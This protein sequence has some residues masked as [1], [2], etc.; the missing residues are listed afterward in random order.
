MTTL[1]VLPTVII[2]QKKELC[3]PGK[4]HGEL[5]EEK[6]EGIETLLLRL[7]GMNEAFSKMKPVKVQNSA[8]K[9]RL[10]SS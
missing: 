10:V 7:E 5:T 4:F 8:T 9:P 2:R 6:D 3:P 1:L